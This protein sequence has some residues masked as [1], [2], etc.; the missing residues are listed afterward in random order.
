MAVYTGWM[1]PAIDSPLT[2][3]QVH[4]WHKAFL[5]LNGARLKVARSL[6]TSR[7]QV[8]LD[9]LPL[10]LHLNH[11]AMPGFISHAVPC[12]IAH[13]TPAEQQ[14]QSLQSIARG[15]QLPRGFNP[16]QISGLYLMGSLGSLAQ[17]RSSDM[18]VW[19]CY[20][21][22]L[23]AAEL[24][25]LRQKCQL[26][27]QWAA[28]QGAELHI[29]LMNLSE[30]RAGQSQTA[31]GDD[32][33][34]TQHGL[35]LDEFYRSALW[36]AG[37]QPRWWL[38]PN[39][40]ERRADAFWQALVHNHRVN[41]DHWLDFGAMPGIAPSEFVGAG[42]W[43]LNKGLHDPYKSLLKLLITRH[44]AAQYPNIRPLCWDLK[45]QVHNG[46]SDAENNDAYLLMLARLTAQL[47]REGNTE[48]VQL[49]RRAFYYKARL[50]L[51]EL[52]RSQRNSWRA[53]TLQALCQSWGWS[54]DYLQELD[55]RP[56]WSPLKVA[57]ERNAL[58]SEM[59]S[60]YRFLA[61]FS[62][63]YAPRLLIS[64]QDTRTLGNRL[65][66]AFD[67]RPGK[68][69]D[70]NPGIVRSLGQE[71][72]ALNLKRNIWQLIPGVFYRSDNEQLEHEQVLRQSPS[73]VELLCFA[74]VNGL[75]ENYTRFAIYPTHNPLSQYELKEISQVVR[76]IEPYRPQSQ[77]F[78]Q[79]A[80]PLQWFLMVNAGVDP[81]HELSRRGMQK[82]S[83]RDDALGY[84]SARENL[85]QTIDLITVNSWGEWLV[86]RFS[87]D[88]GMMQCLQSMLQQQPLAA[89]DG[90]PVWSVHCYCASR[91]SAIR[92]RVE[93]LL[94]DVLQ[95]FLQQPKSP[96]LIEA[97]ETWYLLEQDGKEMELRVADSPT[98]LLALLARPQR[99]FI[100]YTLDR[101][102]L[103]SSPL[104][105][106]FEQARAGVWQLFYWRRDDR[107]Y[108]YFLD[109]KGALLHQQWPDTEG[110]S[111]HWLLPVLRFLRQ[112]DLR[113][114]RQDGR[115][116]PRKILLYELRHRHQSYDFE[117]I[118]RR[119]P[120]LPVQNSVLDLRAVLDNHQQET[121]YCDGM[122]FSPWEYGAD[123]HR[124]VVQEVLARRG[125]HLSYP[126]FLTDVELPD[127]QNMIEHLQVKQRLENRLMQALK[128]LRGRG[129]AIREA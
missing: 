128:D 87:G 36:L 125:S 90:W 104:R 60:S 12:G 63:K 29:F 88:A 82:L 50:P 51:S 93:Q 67:N 121:F 40:E 94:E 123:L 4:Q 47:E 72:L 7:Q 61:A 129:G 110:S 96:Y 16:R 102:A 10:L 112:V 84:S 53:E 80:Q 76:A 3:Q 66:A 19:L 113:W 42:L 56:Q 55:Q 64:R 75:L 17:A 126:L 95:H 59:L 68:I 45:E 26:L 39:A 21:E 103:L 97:A 31:D 106:V 118:R 54:A 107:L 79:P 28:S 73:L 122:E 58:I 71:K 20:S 35:L 5:H 124:E 83:N 74:R 49:A 32:C 38:I 109:E 41:A 33:G 62:Q 44:Y 65:Y 127:S 43:Q 98:K 70:I 119:I 57:R 89:R 116:Q 69:M 34:S 77:D 52:S 23:A 13:F 15:V 85:I 114:Q 6:M 25:G 100:G 8:V 117:L 108:L 101:S 9:V 99:Q 46:C 115:S 120:D 24:E 91:A 14:L 22:Q 105:L 111:Q 92:L 30:F 81:Q 18:D 78:M 37:R 86:Q 2:Q 1:I 48:R 27:E 11:P